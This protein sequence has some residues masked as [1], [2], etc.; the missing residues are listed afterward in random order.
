M[1]IR[2]SKR[3][4]GPKTLEG[5]V[6][7]SRNAVKTGSYSS[8]IALSAEEEADFKAFEDEFMYDFEPQG[9]VESSMVHELAVLA[10]KKLRLER[11]E[12]QLM[13]DQL[14]SPITPQEYIDA[15]FV[16][17]DVAE[18]ALKQLDRMDDQFIATHTKDLELAR[19]LKKDRHNES[20]IKSLDQDHPDFYVRLQKV[21]RQLDR[22]PQKVIYAW[23]GIDN[24]K[25]S[26]N[27]KPSAADI[28]PSLLTE[29]FDQVTEES[30]A[31]IHVSKNIELIQGLKSKILDK[32]LM[33]MMESA[34]SHRVH[35]DLGRLFSRRLKELREQQSWRIKR[36]IIDVLSE[37]E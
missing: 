22:G 20:R 14:K 25:P 9:V 15:G 10:W 34:T 6:A 7:S 26:Y 27:T 31:V 4:G 21:V 12:H 29:A 11:V 18:F 19:S 37:D 33:A 13:R 30:E 16:G 35:E 23:T 1:A 24:D 5:K 17:K 32:R 28:P 36:D 2:K 8:Q 3:S